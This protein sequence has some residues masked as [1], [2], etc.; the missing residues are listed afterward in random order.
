[1]SYPISHS[2][3]A[4]AGWA[5]L[6]AALYWKISRYRPGALA[7][8][9]G[10][11]S[12]WVLDLLVHRPDLPLYPGGPK[13]GLGLWNSLPGTLIAE[14]LFFGVGVWLYAKSTRAA[15]RGG[16][17]GWWVFVAFLVL[18]YAANLVGPP[19]ARVEEVAFVALA[20]WLMPIWAWSI[21]RRRTIAVVDGAR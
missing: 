5:A 10:V 12:H 3:L 20:L 1:M 14:A 17:L 7:I 16:H 13:A 19:P 6:A 21:D 15:S 4:V 8:A 11:I 9:A 2:L 18:V